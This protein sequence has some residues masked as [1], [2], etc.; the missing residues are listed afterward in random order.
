MKVEDQI[1]F[2]NL[3]RDERKMVDV[4]WLMNDS[5]EMHKCCTTTHREHTT[6][7]ILH[8]RNSDQEFPHSGE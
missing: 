8:F 7:M 6:E 2:A 4:A 5:F 3:E 1:E